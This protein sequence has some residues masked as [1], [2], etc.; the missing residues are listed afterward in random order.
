MSFP[1]LAQST[2]AAAL[3]LLVLILMVQ[4]FYAIKCVFM[5]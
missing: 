2:A 3:V 4:S 5:L 1:P